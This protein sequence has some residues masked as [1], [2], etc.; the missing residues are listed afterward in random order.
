VETPFLDEAA[1]GD[2]TR[3]ERLR[4]GREDAADAGPE[5]IR[6]DEEIA[7]RSRAVRKGGRHCPLI[8]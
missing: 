8:L 5:P 4:L 1:P 3:I 6:A 7:C 2:V